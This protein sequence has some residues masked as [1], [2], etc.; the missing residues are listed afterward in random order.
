MVALVEP[1]LATL[2]TATRLVDWGRRVV[3]LA[4]HTIDGS[5]GG[6]PSC[7]RTLVDK[8]GDGG[9][10][11]AARGGASCC[12]DGGD[13]EG[14]GGEPETEAEQVRAMK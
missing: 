13:Q 6:S 2:L 8:G 7:L 1:A 9:R 11:R 14:P 4:G 12:G 10:G 5:G 3:A